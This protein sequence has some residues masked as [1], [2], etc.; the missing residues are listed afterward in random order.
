MFPD[1]GSDIVNFT[2][3]EGP[4]D[5]KGSWE[6]SHGGSESCFMLRLEQDQNRS[7]WRPRRHILTAAD[8]ESTTDARNTMDPLLSSPHSGSSGKLV[9]R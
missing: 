6:A 5:Q 7:P 2:P 4:S 8:K 1:S 9:G 3:P